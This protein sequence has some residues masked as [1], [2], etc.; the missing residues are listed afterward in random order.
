MISEK[1]RR[2]LLDVAAESIRH[3]LDHGRPLTVCAADY[4]EELRVPR[5]TFVTLHRHGELRG[6]IGML[7]AVRPLV[8][9]VAHNSY[10][11]AFED[12]RFAPLAAWELEGLD[13]HISVLSP[14][15]CM[16][17]ASEADLLQQLRPGIDGLI[18]RDSHCRG[19]FL[20]SVWESLSD[21][22]DF[23]RHLKRKAGL[24]ADWWSD[25]LTVERYTTE[26]FGSPIREQ[27]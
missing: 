13:L 16:T 20:P 23:L 17:C 27:E 21:P 3:G 6:C 19:T 18:L 11:A 10:A 5:A 15:E 1:A 9:D 14:P 25:T 7:E 12:P 22:C 2:L 4:P 24:P 26:S 8:E